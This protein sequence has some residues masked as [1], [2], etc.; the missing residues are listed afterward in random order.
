MNAIDVVY[1]LEKIIEPVKI[2]E[3]YNNYAPNIHFYNEQN[4]YDEDQNSNSSDESDS[5]DDNLFEYSNSYTRKPKKTSSKYHLVSGYS[6]GDT[7][8]KAYARG[9]TP[10][11]LKKKT[12]VSGYVNKNGTKVKAYTR[13]KNK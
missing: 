11:S 6:R 2:P 1:E 9:N 7:K 8:V 5:L 3:Y 4:Y 10:A 13:K 12:I